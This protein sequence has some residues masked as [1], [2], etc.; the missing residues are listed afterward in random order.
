MNAERIVERSVRYSIPL[1]TIASAGC[2]MFVRHIPANGDFHG[3][4]IDTTVDHES[5]KYFLEDYV[6][7]K[8]KASSRRQRVSSLERESGNSIPTREQL[9]KIS[10]EFSVDFAALFFAHRL[11]QEEGNEQLQRDFLRNLDRVRAGSIA[12]PRK[13]ILIMLV[14]GYDYKDN[15][16]LTGADLRKPRAL[17]EAAGY[18]VDFV[19]ID[20]LGSVE[21][22]AAYLKSR[23]LARRGRK[24]A[25]AGPSS[26]GPAIH[27][28]LG[29]L[30]TTDESKDVL[31]WLNLGGIL[32]G[33]PLL[34]QFDRGLKGWLFAA[35]L[36]L[37]NWK[38]HSFESMQA[39]VSRIRFKSL[40]VPEHVVIYNYVGL[41]LSGD[42]SRFGR[43]KYS[44]M[45]VDG[46]NDGLTLLPDIIA[47]NS[48]TI[49][50]PK[51]DHFFAEDPEIDKKTLA[52]LM[53]IFERLE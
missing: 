2:L 26:A 35:I 9:R 49:L 38:K 51:T 52:F 40:N 17:I 4:S 43:D 3:H 37:K 10:E 28:A 44:M 5:A 39:G 24:V 32:Q 6:S 19:D 20:P 27:L 18:E 50:S 53:T 48:K 13:D 8:D 21:E 47:P 23:L 11:M 46:P 7:G 30:L 22:N 14:P 45:K 33:S 12:Y 36:W 34:D 41:S 42:I 29:K 25:L 15:G 16:H 1:L 31:A